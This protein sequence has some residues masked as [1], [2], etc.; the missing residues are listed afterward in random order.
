MVIWC[1]VFYD[2]FPAYCTPTVSFQRENVVVARMGSAYIQLLDRYIVGYLCFVVVETA[3][4][5]AN[6][7]S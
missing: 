3:I 2:F 6:S 1:V 7:F 5:A 4:R